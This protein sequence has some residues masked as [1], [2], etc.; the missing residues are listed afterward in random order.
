VIFDKNPFLFNFADE[1]ISDTV[2]FLELSTE[3]YQRLST[4]PVAKMLEITA[5]KK[6]LSSIKLTSNPNLDPNSIL[7]IV[8]MLEFDKFLSSL[9]MGLKKKAS[10]V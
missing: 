4:S 3:H 5:K 7:K 8:T 10:L 6:S 1:N 9:A 2:V